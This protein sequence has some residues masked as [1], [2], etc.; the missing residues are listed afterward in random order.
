MI[1]ACTLSVR[2]LPLS[3]KELRLRPR[4]TGIIIDVAGGDT[5]SKIEPRDQDED[6]LG[7]FSSI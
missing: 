3:I 2:A 7:F 5:G 1:M 6:R 4:I